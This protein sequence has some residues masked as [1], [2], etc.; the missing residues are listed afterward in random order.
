MG[1]KQEPASKTQRPT[2]QLFDLVGKYIYQMAS[3]LGTVNSL[4]GLYKGV[5]IPT[6]IALTLG[7][8]ESV[9]KGLGLERLQG[10]LVFEETPRDPQPEVQDFLM[11]FQIKHDRKLG[12]RV[13]NYGQAHA[14]RNAELSK[15]GGETWQRFPEARVIYVGPPPFPP[16]TLH[17]RTVMHGS[18]ITYEIPVYSVLGHTVDEME[19]D[20]LHL[21]MP[22][23]VLRRRKEASSAKTTEERRKELIQETLET[24]LQ[25]EACLERGCT[26][27]IITES[28][29]TMLLEIMET[30]Y[31]ELYETQEGVMDFAEQLKLKGFKLKYPEWKAEKDRWEAEKVEAVRRTAQERDTKIF[32]L[33]DQGY[34]RE[35]VKAMLAQEY[36]AASGGSQPAST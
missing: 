21:L 20:K 35:E 4:R 3:A 29:A 34:T 27:E 10:D 32:S 24:A 19:Q 18:E 1:N 2:F 11:E 36:P 7:R 12:L 28:D 14:Q 31:N 8:T 30:L 13:F 9:R 17:V 22:F 33:L 6:E 15:N 23:Q 26:A 25:I 16:E 5:E